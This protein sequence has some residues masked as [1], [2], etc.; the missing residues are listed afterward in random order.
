MISWFWRHIVGNLHTHEWKIIREAPLVD[1]DHVM[2]G[3][4][5]YL[6]CQHC[7]DVKER[8]FYA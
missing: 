5:Y 3:Y 1:D 8:K 4:K 6:Q 7:G 2:V